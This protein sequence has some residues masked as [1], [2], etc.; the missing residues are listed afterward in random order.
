MNKNKKG[1]PDMSTHRHG[2]RVKPKDHLKPED[3]ALILDVSRNAL[4]KWAREGLVKVTK[5]G[6]LNRFPAEEI[7]RL[8]WE[9]SPRALAERRILAVDDV[10]ARTNREIDKEAWNGRRKD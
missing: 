10:V 4:T 7:K 1:E 8:V 3:A 5:V 9:R 6:R 2:S